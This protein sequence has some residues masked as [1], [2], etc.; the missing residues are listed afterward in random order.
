[1]S[2]LS[3]RVVKPEPDPQAARRREEHEES[4]YAYVRSHEDFEA[5]EDDYELDDGY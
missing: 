5:E 1:M 3:E 2:G 4:E